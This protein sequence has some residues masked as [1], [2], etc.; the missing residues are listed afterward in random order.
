MSTIEQTSTTTGNPAQQT[1]EEFMAACLADGT[2]R[3]VCQARWDAAHQT[4]PTVPPAQESPASTGTPSMGDLI[5]ENEMLRARIK[6][7]EDQ[8]KQ[9]IE[10]ANRANDQNKAK[11]NAQKRMLIDSIQM[12]SHFAKDE[13]EKKTLSELQVIRLTLDKSMAKTF[14]SVAADI[15]AENQKKQPLLT[16]G[17][18]DREKKRWVGGISFT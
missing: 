2:S 3:E 7:R 1:E 12:D 5:R 8:L 16:A 14:A 10:I 17:A 9:A 13:L 15:A 4:N 18:W 6:V 11:D